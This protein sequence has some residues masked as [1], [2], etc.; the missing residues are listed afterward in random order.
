MAL[1][2]LAMGASFIGLAQAQ[3]GT[4]AKI[5]ERGKLIDDVV[6]CGPRPE[7]KSP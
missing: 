6:G 5:K 4:I 1:A 7:G 3:Q 2:A